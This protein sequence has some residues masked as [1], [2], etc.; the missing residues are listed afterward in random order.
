MSGINKIKISKQILK[1]L[2][3]KG[4]MKDV[5][6]FRDDK[7]YYGENKE[8]L[9]VTTVKGFYHKGNSI[10]FNLTESASITTNSQEKLLV[11]YDENSLKIKVNDYFFIEQREFE[12]DNK[13]LK[14]EKYTILDKGDIEGIVYDMFLERR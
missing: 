7:N 8:G 12:E 11:I 4:L 5:V 2:T 9:Y 3:S 14:K 10:S 1:A 13:T 6:I